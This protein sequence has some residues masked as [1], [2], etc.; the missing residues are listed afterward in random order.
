MSKDPLQWFKETVFELEEYWNDGNVGNTCEFSTN[1]DNLL[2]KITILNESSNRVSR[3]IWGIFECDTCTE[4]SDG[5]NPLHVHITN[6]M[7][8]S[9]VFKHHQ[10]TYR[11]LQ[12][13]WKLRDSDKCLVSVDMLEDVLKTLDPQ[14][15]LGLEISLIIDQSK[16]TQEALNVILH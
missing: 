2:E 3:D 16:I 5:E 14:S 6:C 12:I 10:A 9:E 7:D 1:T 11:I 4:H 15:D 13:A 8:H